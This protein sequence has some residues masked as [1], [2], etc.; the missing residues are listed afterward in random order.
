M[1]ARPRK[2]TSNPT[3]LS[4][5]KFGNQAEEALVLLRSLDH[6]IIPFQPWK[7]T[8]ACRPRKAARGFRKLW[9][10]G[11]QVK[12]EKGLQMSRDVIFLPGNTRRIP[13]RV[14]RKRE[15]FVM[16]LLTRE[17]KKIL[18]NG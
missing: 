7:K 15:R 8:T 9:R 11:Y 18:N 4:L 5:P 13:K 10:R 16:D 14:A 3:T 6:G 17:A 12:K 2:K 1:S